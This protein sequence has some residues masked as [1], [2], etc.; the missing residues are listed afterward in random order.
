[1]KYSRTAIGLL[2]A[3]YRSV[4]KKCLLINLGLYALGAVA[5]TPAMADQTVITD[6]ATLSG[7]TYQ[8]STAN[9]DGGVFFVNAEG[10]TVEINSSAFTGNSVTGEGAT[11]GAISLRRGTLNIDD[12]V[13]T[14]NKAPYSGAIFTYSAGN[15]LKITN[16]QFNSNVALGAG[17]LQAMFETEIKNTSF[18][19]NRATEDS[20]GAGALFVGA[21]GKTKLDNVTFTENT[22]ATRGGA[23]G[24]RSFTLGD[25]HAA[26]IDIASSEFKNNT[27]ATLGGAINNFMYNSTSHEGAVFVG[28]ST[29]TS[30]SAT[31]GGAVYNHIGKDGDIKVGGET[32]I[33]KIYFKDT[34]FTDNTASEKGGALYNEGEATIAANAA[35]VAFS[36]NTAGGVA[37]DIFNLGTLT[38]N[39]ASG[40]TISLAGGIDGDA[41]SKG[42]TNV[43][44]EGS[45]EVANALKNQNVNNTGTLKLNGAD[46]TGTTISGNGK[47]KVVGDSEMTG[48]NTISQNLE[49]EEGQELSIGKAGEATTINGTGTLKNLAGGTL[50]IKDA[51]INVAVNNAGILYSDP[52]YYTEQVVNSG[53]ATFDGDIFDTGS[54]LNNTATVNL[55]NGTEFKSGVAI[56]GT[57]TTNLTSGVMH[58]NNTANANKINVFNGANF[59]GTIVGGTINTQNGIIDAIMGSIQNANVAIDV[60]TSSLTADTFAGGATGSTIKSINVSGGYGTEDTVSVNLASGLTLAGDAEINGGYYTKVEV[61]EGKLKFSD[62]LVNTSTIRGT[63]DGSTTFTGNVVLG[64]KADN[65]TIGTPNAKIVMDESDKQVDITAGTATKGAMV[66]LD[67]GSVNLETANSTSKGEVK[68]SSDATNNKAEM[69]AVYNSTDTASVVVQADSTNG[70]K[71]TATAANGFVVS[72][73]TNNATLKGTAAGLNVAEGIT[74]GTAGTYGINASGVAK[75]NGLTV[76]TTSYGITNTGAASVASLSL[77]GTA[78]TAT[79]GEINQLHGS[80]VTTADLTKLHGVTA[81]AAELNK[82][83]GNEVTA[84][85][86]TKLSEVTATSAE[87]NVLDGITASTAELNQLTGSGVTTADLTKLH[88]VTASADELNL[89]DGMTATTASKINYANK[90]ATTLATAKSV[91]DALGRIDGLVEDNGD[92]TYT[93]HTTAGDVTLNYTNLPVGTSVE[94]VVLMLNTTVGDRNYV[95]NRSYAGS[96]LSD[97]QAISDSIFNVATKLDDVDTIVGPA[98]TA[99]ATKGMLVG[100]KIGDDIDLVNAIDFVAQNAVS[101]TTDNV[102]TGENTFKNTNGIHLQNNVGGNDTNLKATA[103]GLTVDRNV[104]ATGFKISTGAPVVTSIDVNGSGVTSASAAESI[105]A[106]A[107]TVYNG[108]ENGLYNGT[109]VSGDTTSTTIKQ[110]LTATNSTLNNILIADGSGVDAAKVSVLWNGANTTLSGALGNGIYTGATHVSAGDDL[111]TAVKKVDAALGADLTTV[112]TRTTGGLLTTNS[113][114]E[115]IS[116]LDTAIGG[117]VTSTNYVAAANSV[118]ANISALDTQVKT[119]TD[120]MTVAANGNYI[121]AGANVKGNLGLLDTQVKGNADDISNIVADMTVATDGN[122]ILAGAD[123]KGNLGALDTAVKG[124]ADDISDIQTAITV[125]T[126]GNY[127]ATGNDVAGNL[128]ALDTQVK[129]NADDI[130]TNAVIGTASVSSA[131]YAATATVKEAVVAIDAALLADETQISTNKT[132]IGTLTSL[133]TD[134]KTDLV[135]AINEVDGHADAAQTE[136]DNVET[137]LGVVNA[138]GTYKA[139]A[140]NNNMFENGGTAATSLDGALL[141]LA[142]NTTTM[143]GASIDDSGNLKADY[144]SNNYVADNSNLVTAVGALDAQ[145]KINADKNT[146]QD[147]GMGN[148]ASRIGVTYTATD[149]SVSATDYAYTNYVADG[150]S[151]VTAVGK[152]DN[153]LHTADSNNAKLDADNIFTGHNTFNNANGITI[154]DGSAGNSTNITATANGLTVDR[155]VEAAGFKIAGQTPV[156]TSIDVDGSGVT[157]AATAA[158]IM[159]TAATVYNGAENGAYTGTKVTGDTTSTTIKDAMSATTAALNNVLT[160]DGSKVDAAKVATSWNGVDSNVAAALGNGVYGST[161]KVAAGDSVT[162]AITKLDT[163]I[164]GTVTGTNGNVLAANSINQNL[165][166]IDVNMGNLTALTTTEK[167]SL[168]GSINEI[169]SDITVGAGTYNTISAG[170]NVAANLIALDNVAGAADEKI[171]SVANNIGGTWSGN[172]FTHSD[173]NAAN[174]NILNTDNLTTAIGKLDT[175]LGNIASVTNTNGNI[176]GADV[177]AK[178]DTID[179]NM[180]KLSTLSTTEKGSLVGSINEV[181]NDIT[182]GTGSYNVITAGANVAGNLTA[183]DSA[184]TDGTIDAKFKSVTIDKAY[185]ITGTTTGHLDMGGNTLDNVNGMVLTN[186]TSDVALTVNTSGNLE[187]DKGIKAAS[188]ES[189][190]DLTVGGAATITG[191][192]QGSTATFSGAVNV[193]SLEIGGTG[194]G[195]TSTGAAKMDTVEAVNGLTVGK[196]NALTSTVSGQLDMGANDLTNIKNL[197][198]TGNATIAGDLGVAGTS[199]LHDTNVEGNFTIVDTADPTKKVTMDVRNITA[200]SAAVSVLQTNGDSLTTGTL[201]TS[202]RLKV[203][204]KTATDTYTT[205]FDVTATDGSITSDMLSTNNTGNTV[206]IGKD[207]SSVTTVKG[208]ENVTGNITVQDT[209]TSSTA[210]VEIKNDG[211]VKTTDTTGAKTVELKNG[212]ATA[213][214]AVTAGTVNATTGALTAGVQMKNDAT[215]TATDGTETA[216]YDAAG[217]R[218]NKGVADAAADDTFK[219]DSTNGNVDTVGDVTVQAYGATAK[220]EIDNAGAVKTTDSTG[221]KTVEMKDGVMTATD[222]ALIQATGGTTKVE[223]DNTGKITSKGANHD[224]VINDGDVDTYSLTMANAEQPSTATSTVKAT[225]KTIDIADSIQTLDSTYAVTTAQKEA[226]ATVST[227]LNSAENAIYRPI[228][229]LTGAD[230]EYATAESQTL[231]E[232]IADIDLRIGDFAQLHDSDNLDNYGQGSTDTVVDLLNN[233]DSTLGTIHN[234]ADARGDAY[235]GNLGAA[236]DEGTTVEQHLVALDDAIGDRRNYT[237]QYNIENNQ[238]VADSLNAMDL[239]MGDVASLGRE[240]HYY[241]DPNPASVNLSSAVKSLD[242]NLYRLEMDHKKLRHETHAGLASAAALSAL[243]PNP[244]GTGDTTLSFGTGAYQ[245]HT[246]AAFGGFHWITNNLLVNAGVGWDNRE[247]TTRIGVSYS[248]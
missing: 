127:I 122:Y 195:I 196:A 247:A 131:N 70:A 4:L 115:N 230:T 103:N 62:K 126:A 138:D 204:K 41:N 246:A 33:A 176:T 161:N 145:A 74:V 106:T 180:G 202:D 120:N 192:L 79:A 173:Y 90:G 146:V 152:L 200:D 164:G 119:N 226:L 69:K 208:N 89:L 233:I 149:G 227:V 17:A 132:N 135:S 55:L 134:V 162:T 42:T 73:G 236:S 112:Q 43:S 12:T 1:M 179:T 144:S 84:A 19:G 3:Q 98:Q 124:N 9:D 235:K 160:T 64:S 142:S 244:R 158:N 174:K 46:L 100:Q 215:I 189:T 59:D 8:N 219:V 190:G 175:I 6:N 228:D 205:V 105:M 201:A 155:N 38:L 217:I 30:N 81:T 67:E 27:A 231:N 130:A 129:K 239:R 104:E 172:V 193:G 245:G 56:T 188:L 22:S 139:A 168:V 185:A 11:G 232:A 221:T 136:I 248:F 61:A 65:T 241:S 163:A 49:V 178:L 184:F 108:A 198:T 20:S 66:G 212:A 147:T 87:L 181:V 93:Y 214:D 110:A 128:G 16:S 10:K 58:F 220:V 211:S 77:G 53:I 199:N 88:G 171:T 186:G 153:A 101:L 159:A 224:V 48:E 85:D 40:K 18:T 223:I 137:A 218:L 45:V 51:H 75:V 21:V 54:S 2:T 150:D 107:A 225:V 229:A 96:L 167:G 203:V 133:S 7:E 25:N 102:F 113:A 141:N 118:N 78:V 209:L 72:D 197:T 240:M 216:H 94:D 121:L 26:M 29:F 242:S 116:A 234:L 237:A 151:L 82:L 23:I 52:T 36:G 170:A 123:V 92:G 14:N 47:M 243:V 148:L 165:D 207:A 222:K 60:N 187:A 44:G 238:S 31:N 68:V 32:Q 154:Q 63:G 143:T 86:L 114:N 156:V 97:G 140:L 39:A 83:A 99:A 213:S 183:L 28:S 76:G 71:V 117:D 95:T 111:T 5:A 191:D 166:K 182:V 194:Y 206:T 57:G 34:N 125:T 50:N 37:N 35:D 169:V 177:A 24:S 15:K 80:G 91:Y 109:K 157:S 210:K 13:F